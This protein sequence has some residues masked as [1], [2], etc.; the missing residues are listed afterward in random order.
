MSGTVPGPESPDRLSRKPDHERKRRLRRSLLLASALVLLASAACSWWIASYAFSPSTPDHG[1]TVLVPRGAGAREIQ[2]ILARHDLIGDD[3]RFLVLAYLTRTAGR[4]RAGEYL[5]PPRQTPLQI[6]RL[7]EK[8]KVVLHPVTIPEGSNIVQITRI[9]E[10][11]G[12]INGPLFMRLA[13]DPAF[14]ETLGLDLP[15]LEGYLFPDTYLLT[16]GEVTEKS[17]LT[18]MVNRFLA[19]WAALTA[20]TAPEMSRH[21]VITLASMVEKEA[22]KPEERPII[23]GV[24]LNR[25]A[26]KM[27]LQSDPTVIYGLNEF[28]GNLTR[29][30]LKR[31]TAYNTYVVDGLPQGP[32]CSPGRE[33]IEAV[34]DPAEVPFLYFVSKNDGTHH[35]SV[36]LK[37]HNEAVYRYQILPAR[38]QKSSGQL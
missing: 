38:R 37:E 12:W 15:S 4:L 29:E 20:N 13:G 9:L 24:F 33:S 2:S 28:D 35:F 22:A 16:R 19:V 27:R 34:L 18:M 31:E 5:I 11:G 10:G 17:L 7:L 30:D 8:G 1:T 14:I 25:L 3:S 21:Q 23:A 26:R 36:T 32:I 6:L